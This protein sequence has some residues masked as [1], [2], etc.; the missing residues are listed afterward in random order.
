MSL[1]A[2]RGRLPALAT[3]VL[4]IAVLA[5]AATVAQDEPQT[6][7]SI[8]V[9]IEGEPTSV[10][11]AFDY[12][13]VL[14]LRHI[15]HHGAAAGVLRERHRSC[16]PT[17]RATGPS[18]RTAS[19]TPSHP[20]GGQLPR[21]D[22]DDGGRRRLQP[23]PDPRPGAR[24]LRGL[25]ARQRGRHPGG[26]PDVDG[27]DEPAGRPD[28]V[29][30]RLDGGARRQ[31]GRSSRSTATDYGT[32]SVGSIGTGPFKFVE[33]VSGDHQT[34]ARND[35]YWD[36]ASGGPYLDEVVIKFLP[37]PTTRVAGL[38][39]ARS[40]TSS[41]TCPRTSTR[42]SRRWKRQP[43]VMPSYYGEWITFNTQS[44]AVR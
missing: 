12:D 34:L 44:P 27:H 25:D 40:T 16:A 20:R 43:D 4:T 33:W 9:A 42:P 10:D 29:R 13:F 18:A 1:L 37:E 28:R 41:T 11:P 21:R 14:R 36:K 19:R 15:Q 26:R 23:E 32:P 30:A 38:D 5:P 7:G 39:T 35:D 2:S 8:T 6:G 31:A 3:I 17:S 22:A 24:L